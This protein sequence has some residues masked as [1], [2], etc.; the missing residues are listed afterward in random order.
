MA[1]RVPART[2]LATLTAA[3]LSAGCAATPAPRAPV[4]GPPRPLWEL[5]P[6]GASAGVVVRDGA[7]VRAL[8]LLDG[9]GPVPSMGKRAAARQKVLSPLSATDGWT[10]AGLDPALG[11]AV[12]IWPEKERGALLVL[13]VRDR[14]RFRD[15][16]HL[17]TSPAGARPI[18]DLGGGY[19]CAPAAGRYLCARSLDEIDAA[20]APHASGLGRAVDKLPGEDHGDVEIYAGPRVKEMARLREKSRTLGLL[21]GVAAS[22]RF[23]KDGLGARI[24]VL[25]A[26]DTPQALGLAGA[27]PPPELS[28]SATAAP[29][30]VRI[31]LDPATAFP[32]TMTIEPRVRAEL[33]EQMTGDLEIATSGSGVAGLSMTALLRDPARAE[34]LVKDRC[35]ETGG[36][37]RRYAL[38]HVT[39][40][41]HGCAA[42]VTPL[43][44]LLPIALKPFP[45]SATVEGKR[46]VV[47]VGDAHP[48]TAP[49]RAT[50]G[51]VD[52]DAARVALTGTEALVAF[53]RS[54]LVGPEVSAGKAF[55][56]IVPFLD[57]RSTSAIDALDD[58]GVRIY[59]AFFTARVAP[60][61]VIATADVTTFASDPPGARAAYE[62]AL[63]WRAEGDEP[64]YRAALAEVEQRFPETRVGKRAAEVRTGG[65]YVGAGALFLAMLG[66]LGN[67]K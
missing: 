19:L 64:R 3:L 7:P 57:E 60:D 56:D 45:V 67:R 18:D 38:D 48:P 43:M 25:G 24:H 53:T 33:L 5:A 59:Q 37:M 31:H 36:T 21:T 65:P 17:R 66:S 8:E 51:L 41:E 27:P 52:G 40:T 44:L 32:P 35:A 22:I 34:K 62:A 15:A 23:R 12:F 1:Q 47:L 20:A 63:G 39:A 26:T 14:A 13:P 28:P 58:V 11:A 42:V 16:F 30:V 50:A 6:E 49:E 10:H 29:T 4:D 55:K 54:P 61:G 46:L 9:F 2:T